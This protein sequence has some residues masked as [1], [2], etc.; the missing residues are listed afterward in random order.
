M[1]EKRFQFY[2]DHKRYLIAT[3]HINAQ[4][5]LSWMAADADVVIA[6]SRAKP[7]R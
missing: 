6:I 3:Y 7:T 2:V 1:I 5:Q 4:R